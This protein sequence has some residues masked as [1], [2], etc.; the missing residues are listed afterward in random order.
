MYQPILLIDRNYTIADVNSAACLLM[1]R[2]RDQIIGQPCFQ[3]TH[4]S[5]SPCWQ[6]E[7]ASCPAKLAFALR[8][9]T[10]IIHQHPHEN[11]TR[12]EEIV[13]SPVFDDNGTV[14]Y[15]VEEIRD[16][17]ELL[18]LKEIVEYMKN[19]IKVLRGL[20]PIC[21]SCKKVRDD[22]GYWIQVEMYMEERTG[23][24]FTHSICPECVPKYFPRLADKPK[25]T[26]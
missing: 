19:E 17:T 14:N 21:A 9:Q 10:R 3:I 11:Q 2:T 13:A 24:E 1:N 22:E 15:V 25:K 6:S 7:E 12:V 20:I 18:N 23:A 5:E 26:P 16:I 4:N 8:K